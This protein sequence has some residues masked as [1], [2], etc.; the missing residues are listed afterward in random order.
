MMATTDT[1]SLSPVEVDT[2]LAALYSALSKAENRRKGVVRA[3]RRLLS[4][5]SLAPWEELSLAD[6]NKSLG[7]CEKEIARL[8]D[9]IAPLQAEWVARG[10]WARYFLVNNT[11]GHVH[12]SMHCKT[13][14]PTTR[15]S[16]LVD[17]ADQPV[18]DMIEEWGEMAC[19]VCWPDA[20]SHPRF[21]EPSR[22]TQEERRIAAEAKAAK[23]AAKA[24]KAITA[25]DGST[26][27]GRLGPVRT[28]ASAKVELT[29]AVES[30]SVPHLAAVYE[31]EHAAVR[32]RLAAAIAAKLGTTPE[33]EIAAA[34]KRAARRR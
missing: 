28:L 23:E 25:P 29:D 21:S 17:L 27:L 7:S 24:A 33:A 30:L 34:V 1:A 13:C 22:R 4:Q 32:D 26:L 2:Q 20:P 8:S 15:F 11:G 6:Y 3:I 19:T 31:A 16:W 10:R 5:R 12:S 14:F 18:A 9:S